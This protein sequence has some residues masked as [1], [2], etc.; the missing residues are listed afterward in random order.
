MIFGM[1]MPQN[2]L[3]VIFLFCKGPGTTFLVPPL[4]PALDMKEVA[5]ATKCDRTRP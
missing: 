4:N 3:W 5:M 1:Q 2:C